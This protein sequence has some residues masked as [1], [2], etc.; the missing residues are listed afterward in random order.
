MKA[1]FHHDVEFIESMS[2]GLLGQ[3]FSDESSRIVEGL[4]PDLGLMFRSLSALACGLCIG[5]IMVFA[6]LSPIL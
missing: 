4:G 5:F 6:V 2:P 1:L 3:R